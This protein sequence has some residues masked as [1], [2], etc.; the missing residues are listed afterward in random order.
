VAAGDIVFSS[1][2]SIFRHVAS[3]CFECFSYF[4]CMFQVFH[5]DVVKVDRDVTYVT[6]VARVC[7][8]RLFPM[9]HLFFQ[10][11]VAYVSHICCECFYL[12]VAYVCNGF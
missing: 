8:K 5:M 10:M 1:I 12:D 7:C 4:R 11:Y 3:L 2:S 6:V 9:F